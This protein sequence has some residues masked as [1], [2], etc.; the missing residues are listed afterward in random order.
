MKKRIDDK[1]KEMERY[2]EELECFIPESFKDYEK[3]FEK[4]AACERYFERIAE[5]TADL[6]FLCIRHNEIELPDG[7]KEAFDA[8]AKAK[9]I[10]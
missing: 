2:P 9:I 7:D 10:T 4:K 8:L 5:A 1:I 6:A 3:N